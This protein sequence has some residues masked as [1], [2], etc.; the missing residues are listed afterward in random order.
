MLETTAMPDTSD[1]ET[2]LSHAATPDGWTRVI[3]RCAWCQRVYD[4][5]GVGE[6][7]LAIDRMTVVVTDGMCPPC[8]T[9][10]L[11]QLAARRSRTSVAA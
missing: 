7:L 11:A 5:Q 6:R 3:H 1:L 2:L 9:R 4:E 10:T 8:G